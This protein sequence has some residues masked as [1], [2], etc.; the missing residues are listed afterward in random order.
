MWD[1]I[2]GPENPK[3]AAC[4][5]ALATLATRVARED[6]FPLSLECQRQ[7]RAAGSEGDPRYIGTLVT[8]FW[9]AVQRLPLK[10]AGEHLMRFE[11]AGNSQ[12]MLR[13]ASSQA[14]V[15]AVLKVDTSGP[16]YYFHSRSSDDLLLTVDPRFVPPTIRAILE[17][18]ADPSS[19]DSESENTMAPDSSGL[20]VIMSERRVLLNGQD[21]GA[22]TL[23][24]LTFLCR[25][26]EEPRRYRTPEELLEPHDVLDMKKSADRRR[27]QFRVRDVHRTLPPAIQ[28]LIE[29]HGG[30]QES[31]KSG[32]ILPAH[33][34]ARVIET[35]SKA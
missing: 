34:Q 10:D 9:G 13:V 18:K 25:L 3:Q 20:V 11:E 27:H 32:R 21:L 12:A 15:A 2:S 22:V 30:G 4:Q 23:Q 14:E 6:A 5:I 24:A 33:V 7:L 1:D 28:D 8:A 17:P 29:S 19:N 26:I 31:G 16:V 35:R